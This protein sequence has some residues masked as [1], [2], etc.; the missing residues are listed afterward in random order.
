V[1]S[2]DEELGM[3]AGWWEH[4]EKEGEEV[5]GFLAATE[6]LGRL[7][8]EPVVAQGLEDGSWGESGHKLKG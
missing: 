4:A 6:F 7:F 3:G 2:E 5:I 1:E 8:E